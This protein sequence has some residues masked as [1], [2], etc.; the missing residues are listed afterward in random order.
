MILLR[1][2]KNIM[3]EIPFWQLLALNGKQ[4]DENIWLVISREIFD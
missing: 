1:K 2:E 4:A 3:K